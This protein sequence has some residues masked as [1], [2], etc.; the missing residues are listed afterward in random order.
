MPSNRV[1][2]FQLVDESG[3]QIMAAGG[4][5]IVLTANTPDKVSLFDVNQ[6]ATTNPIALNRGSLYCQ[7]AKA[8]KPVDVIVYSPTGHCVFLKGLVPGDRQ[9]VQVDTKQMESR[10]TI[11]FSIADGAANVEKDT[12]L[13]LPTGCLVDPMA[14]AIDVTT[15]DAGQTINVGILSTEASGDAD[16][17]IAA[18]SVATQGVARVTAANG[19]DTIGAL[20][21]VQD[22]VNAGDD[23]PANHTVLST[24]RSVSW[25]LNAGSDTAKGFIEFNVTLALNSGIA[26]L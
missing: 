10:W 21:K 24:S 19:A 8:N 22:S 4:F 1:I 16:G 17:F 13:D 7:V 15:A 14:L 23:F 12:G 5:A 6:A 9:S 25:T 2:N 11:P 18:A 26:S 20:L 3:R